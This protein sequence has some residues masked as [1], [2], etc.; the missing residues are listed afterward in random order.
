MFFPDKLEVVTVGGSMF[1]GKAPALDR[2]WPIAIA[3]LELIPK[4]CSTVL[5]TTMRDDENAPS[6]YFGNDADPFCRKS[7]LVISVSIYRADPETWFRKSKIK[8]PTEHD[9]HKFQTAFSSWYLRALK[10][11]WVTVGKQLFLSALKK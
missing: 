11:S 10:K 8:T 7:K 1:T 2:V 6:L 5:C 9:W 3:N 4:N